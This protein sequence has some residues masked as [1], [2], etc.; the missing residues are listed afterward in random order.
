MD[1]PGGRRLCKG[2]PLLFTT[3]ARKICRRRSASYRCRDHKQTAVKHNRCI[4]NLLWDTK[5]FRSSFPIGR[6]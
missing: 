2:R 3:N 5:A 1:V 6:E 4:Y